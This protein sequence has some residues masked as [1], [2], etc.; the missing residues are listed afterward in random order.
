MRHPKHGRCYQCGAWVPDREL[1]KVVIPNVIAP[2]DIELCKDCHA[3]RVAQEKAIQR[4]GKGG[5]H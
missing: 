4:A 1:R 2:V 5:V 3:R